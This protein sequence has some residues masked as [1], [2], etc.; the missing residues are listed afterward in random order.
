MTKNEN[1]N[2]F[3]QN[4]LAEET[5]PQELRDELKIV[6]THMLKNSDGEWVT[7]LRAMRDKYSIKVTDLCREIGMQDGLYKTHESGRREYKGEKYEEFFNKVCHALATLQA[8]MYEQSQQVNAKTRKKRTKATKKL[9][10]LALDFNVD[11]EEEEED[12]VYQPLTEDLY[13]KAVELMLNG[14]NLIQ[15]SIKLEVDESA[16]EKRMKK[17]RKELTDDVYNVAVDMLNKRN[18]IEQVTLKLDISLEDLRKRLEKDGKDDF[19]E[20]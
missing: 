14:Y 16:I 1:I 9:N 7:E 18:S 15:A 8:R 20:N 2:E 12:L 4:G 11:D 17:G 6:S 19:F 10:P 3:T 13:E 5:M